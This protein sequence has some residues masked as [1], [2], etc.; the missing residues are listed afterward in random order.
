VL[1]RV[2]QEQYEREYS[3]NEQD[4]LLA[5]REHGLDSKLVG[6]VRDA[7]VR[8]AIEAEGMRVSE[9][10]WAMMQKTFEGTAHGGAVRV[11][12]EMV[13][14]VGGADILMRTPGSALGRAGMEQISRVLESVPM[15]ATGGEGRWLLRE[16]CGCRVPNPA[17]S[18][19]VLPRPQRI[20]HCRL[21]AAADEMLYLIAE[22][23]FGRDPVW[24]DRADALVRSRDLSRELDDLR[25]NFKRHLTGDQRKQVLAFYVDAER[26][27][28]A[29][30]RNVDRTKTTCRLCEATFEDDDV[31]QCLHLRSSH[32]KEW[33][34]LTRLT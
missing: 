8:M 33:R 23:C 3:G 27:I 10:T 24:H 17:K 26:A 2:Y 16:Y 6:D 5:A 29:G 7:G 15:K 14:G 20:V 31:A 30:K 9:A 19:S 13:A 21:H 1:P 34:R 22:I 18:R 11:P 32:L 12:E 4:F 25:R 28:L